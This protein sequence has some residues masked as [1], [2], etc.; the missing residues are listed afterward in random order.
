[1]TKAA[2]PCVLCSQLGESGPAGTSLHVFTFRVREMFPHR[3]P[4][5][6]VPAGAVMLGV[7]AAAPKGWPGA[8]AHQEIPPGLLPGTVVA[9]ALGGS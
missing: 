5:P 3:D 6:Q 8:G 9:A 1:M 4:Q 2:G 7:P